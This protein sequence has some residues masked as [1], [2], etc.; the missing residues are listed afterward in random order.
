M[1]FIKPEQI[2]QYRNDRLQY[3][4]KNDTRK[5]K[6]SLRHLNKLRKTR[7]IRQFEKAYNQDILQAVYGQ[8][9]QDQNSGF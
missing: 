1:K 8:P 9:L 7:E 4:S 5:P 3:F 2:D 6:L